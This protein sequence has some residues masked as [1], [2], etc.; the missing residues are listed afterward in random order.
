LAAV[1]VS[2]VE[3]AVIDQL[4]GE[5]HRAGLLVTE[6]EGLLALHG[7]DDTRLFTFCAGL[8]A[9]Q[10]LVRVARTE[11]GAVD[12]FHDAWSDAV[13]TIRLLR[14]LGATSVF[15]D[16]SVLRSLELALA[17]V[18]EEELGRIRQANILPLTQYDLEHGTELT[19]TLGTYFAHGKNAGATAKALHLH[20]NTVYQRIAR[21]QSLLPESWHEPDRQF[22]IQLSLRLEGLRSGD[23]ISGV[24][25]LPT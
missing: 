25:R 15:V 13:R 17:N 2:S 11:V 22:E 7:L 24:R 14:D 19:H 23:W 8:A 1:H 6:L 4:A 3:P 12:R 20:P 21:C 5:A 16:V 18:G 10:P 9:A